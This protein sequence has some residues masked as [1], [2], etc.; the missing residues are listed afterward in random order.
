MKKSAD[1]WVD[2]YGV[3]CMANWDKRPSVKHRPLVYCD[4]PLEDEIL[5]K[6]WDKSEGKVKVFAR[7]LEL[8]HGIRKY[9]VEHVREPTADVLR[10][11]A[12]A[13]DRGEASEG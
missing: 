13:G 3:F 10:A 2:I 12:E 4:K 8:E 1:Y 11:E 6:L 9:E 7:L 5:K